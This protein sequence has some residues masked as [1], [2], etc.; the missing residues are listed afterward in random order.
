MNVDEY[1]ND[2]AM[3][4][5]YMQ[6]YDGPNTLSDVI[7]ARMM[8]EA[9]QDKPKMIKIELMKDDGKLFVIEVRRVFWTAFVNG[10][11]ST[12]STNRIRLPLN[13]SIT[14]TTLSDIMELVTTKRISNLPG[15]ENA[16][17][18]L[19]DADR[20]SRL[21]IASRVIHIPFLEY[22][23]C[24]YLM[25]DLPKLSKSAAGVLHSLIA[26]NISKLKKNQII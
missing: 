17:I 16:T 8:K 15:Y 6:F 25:H 20:I 9:S 13:S 7:L 24:H 1:T 4:T 11:F 18:S 12:S 26:E 21:Y 2:A 22:Y 5:D 14:S 19:A 10:P 23:I 3:P